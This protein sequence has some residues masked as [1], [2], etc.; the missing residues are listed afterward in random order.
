[1]IELHAGRP[2]LRPNELIF[3]QPLRIKTDPG[4]I[5]PGDLNSVCSLGPEDIK[6]AT[7]R[8]IA[9]IAHQR[10]KAV[11][12]FTEIDRMACQKHFRTGRDHAVRTARINRM[13][14]ASV[15]VASTRII[16]SPIV[17]STVEQLPVG[18]TD[19]RSPLA[20]VFTAAAF[21]RAVRRHVNNCDGSIPMRRAIA[22]TLAPGSM[23]SATACALKS[24]D[25]RRNCRGAPSRGLATASIIWNVLCSDIG[26][27]IAVH[28]RAP[29]FSGTNRTS[30]AHS[31]DG[32]Y[33]SLTLYHTTL[34]TLTLYSPKSHRIK[35][36][37]SKAEGID[38]RL[39]AAWPRDTRIARRRFEL[40]SR[41]YVE[42]RYSSKYKITTE[43]LEWL[44]ER[45]ATLQQL[46]TQI[47][48]ERLENSGQ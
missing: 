1:M 4:T 12:T 19:K 21:S 33:A 10:Q 18:F 45:V 23:A 30:A 8:I 9:G 43:E 24:S 32:V 47:C 22:E 41:A 16:A 17:I 31:P 11:G 46:V 14:C 25:Q 35:T 37:R 38:G 26:A 42:A 29:N 36:L 27:D 40:L 13:R 34:L 15:I 28:T 48:Q 39:I 2:D 6:R 7:E 3:F 20:I 44:T 5:P